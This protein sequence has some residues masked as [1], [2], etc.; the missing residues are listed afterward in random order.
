[1]YNICAR[2]DA[3]RPT[4]DAR[5]YVRLMGD[6]R[7]GVNGQ[8]L[9][10]WDGMRWENEERRTKNEERRVIDGVRNSPA[11]VAIVVYLLPS[12][13]T[14]AAAAAAATASES[15]TRFQFHRL[16]PHRHRI[17]YSLL[18]RYATLASLPLRPVM[19]DPPTRSSSSSCSV[20]RS[21][22]TRKKISVHH[23][24]RRRRCRWVRSSSSSSLRSARK[25]VLVLLLLP[26]PV[27]LPLLGMKRKR[28]QA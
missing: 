19:D 13:S 11:A 25:G 27:L 28:A 12:S 22:L 3:R 4:P 14:A 21:L 23:H 8:W 10:G 5:P 18:Y 9:V 6:L 26:I 15:R 7:K 1:M 17:Q 20:V 16:P 24:R 2:G